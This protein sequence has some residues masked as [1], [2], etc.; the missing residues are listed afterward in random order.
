MFHVMQKL[1]HVSRKN[2]NSIHVLQ[3]NDTNTVITKM[4]PAILKFS[5]VG[6]VA[7]G[8]LLVMPR[9]FMSCN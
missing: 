5:T 7:H 1:N 3:S 2:I 4:H 9:S 8:H 6:I